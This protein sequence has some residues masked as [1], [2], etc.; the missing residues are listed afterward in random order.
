MKDGPQGVFSPGGSN[1]SI[2]GQ[3]TAPP[4]SGRRESVVNVAEVGL[5]PEVSWA[6]LLD[7]M[8]EPGHKRELRLHAQF[9]IF[10]GRT[11]N[12]PQYP[13]PSGLCLRYDNCLIL[14]MYSH[15]NHGACNRHIRHRPPLTAFTVAVNQIASL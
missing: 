1:S 7:L 5:P 6:L 10:A 8:P 13:A 9:S 2:M 4:A 14:S 11:S 12:C 3:V 15:S